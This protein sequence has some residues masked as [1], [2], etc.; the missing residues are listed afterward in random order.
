VAAAARGEAVTIHTS[1]AQRRPSDRLK[2]TKLTKKR[3]SERS[4]AQILLFVA[5]S[6]R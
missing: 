4:P 5:D 1:G 6:K 3:D 2:P